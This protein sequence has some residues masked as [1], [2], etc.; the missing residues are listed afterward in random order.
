KQKVHFWAMC[1]CSLMWMTPNGQAVMQSRQP[2]QAGSLMYTVSNSVRR[3]APVGQTSRHGALTQCLHTSDIISH[4]A[5]LRLG[6]S[7]NC[8][9]N[10]TCRQF[11]SEKLRVL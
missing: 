6:S 4:A 9:M 10:L 2:L 11:T 1:F 8:S 3:M 5:E 7:L